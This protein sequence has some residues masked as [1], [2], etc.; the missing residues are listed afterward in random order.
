M[1]SGSRALVAGLWSGCGSIG[2]LGLTGVCGQGPSPGP[3]GGR[4]WGN[5]NPGLYY[6]SRPEGTW[7]SPHDTSPTRLP[8]SVPSD[9]GLSSKASKVR[10][11][12]R[13]YGTARCTAASEKVHLTRQGLGL[14]LVAGHGSF[15]AAPLSIILIGK[16]FPEVRIL[17][18]G[19]ELQVLPGLLLNP[20]PIPVPHARDFAESAAQIL[21]VA[22]LGGLES[23]R[24][25]H[26]PK[27]ARLKRARIT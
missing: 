17:Q 4:S 12:H 24:R 27:G 11:S 19:P 21:A 10:G 3:T 18:V 6:K 7:G 23:F 2:S 8:V 9:A 22:R 14:V 26:K 13:C 15:G 1:I 20:N 5:G 25:T 16:V